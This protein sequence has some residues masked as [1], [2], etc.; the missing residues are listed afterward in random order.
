[1]Y[2]TYFNSKWCFHSYIDV[3]CKKQTNDIE[4]ALEEF[5]KK[6]IDTVLHR[7]HLINSPLLECVAMMQTLKK[8]RAT[9]LIQELNSLKCHSAPIGRDPCIWFSISKHLERLI[10]VTVLMIFY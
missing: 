7:L 9:H 6:C 1:M 4:H 3:N 8:Y 5:F 10:R 2:Q